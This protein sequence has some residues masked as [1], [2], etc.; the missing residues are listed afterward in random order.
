MRQDQVLEATREILAECKDGVWREDQV[1]NILAGYVAETTM[2]GTLVDMLTAYIE[3]VCA[4]DE[5]MLEP[6]N[7]WS[8]TRNFLHELIERI[9]SDK[10][11]VY[12]SAAREVGD[13]LEVMSPNLLHDRSALS[14][15]KSTLEQWERLTRCA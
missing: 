8:Y 6:K 5:D 1:A 7:L 15:V 13:L 11:F 2:H 12:D 10:Y 14:I 4:Y 3:K 9:K